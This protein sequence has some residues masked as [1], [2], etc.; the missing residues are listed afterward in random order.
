VLITAKAFVSEGGVVLLDAYLFASIPKSM[1][2]NRP[3]HLRFPLVFALGHF[4]SNCDVGG[5]NS[6]R[7]FFLF[8]EEQLWHAKKFTNLR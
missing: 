5:Q 8:V 4:L 3:C 1:E 2:Q 6:I 7:A